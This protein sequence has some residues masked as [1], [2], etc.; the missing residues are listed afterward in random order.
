MCILF[1]ALHSHDRYPVIIAANRDE[2]Y[3]R[4]TSPAEFWDE[5]PE[6]LAGRDLKEG[7]TW[8]GITKTGRI[9]AVTNFRNPR[10]LKEEAPSRGMLVS[11]YLCA[12]ESA[13]RFI[14]HLRGEAERFNGFNI[15]LG[16]YEGLWY[17]SN[18][19]DEAVRLPEG[20]HGISNHLLNT[21]WPKVLR[22]R[23]RL[24]T[25]MKE[26]DDPSP[27]DI[28][29]VLADTSRPDDSLLPDTGVGIEWERILSPLFVVS[30]HY[31]TRSSTCIFVDMKGSARFI[32]RVYNGT[33]SCF[34]TRA[35]AFTM[36]PA[37]H[38]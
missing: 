5:R 14:E 12:D 26:S 3:E 6:V 34:T 11:E 29:E 4:P 37:G 10:T 31:G 38:A 33:P 13:P 19:G 16:D 23:T 28:F 22:A 35:F 9:A 32:E 36:E 27:D 18:V 1:I 17:Y 25:L 21:P 15:V 2:F 7:G 30:P 8:L 20:L 24:G